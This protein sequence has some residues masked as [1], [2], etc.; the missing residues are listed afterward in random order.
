MDR[1][2]VI[3]MFS[4]EMGKLSIGNRMLCSRAQV[5]AHKLRTGNIPT[6]DYQEL[7][8]AVGELAGTKILIEP[9]FEQKDQG[10]ERLVLS[11]GGNFCVYSK[12]F[13]VRTHVS[14]AELCRFSV[15]GES[16]KLV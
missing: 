6:E 14:R 11:C 13:K 12:V 5:D 15:L 9:M 7:N 1:K 10:V 4:L 8:R 16:P 2:P 3:L